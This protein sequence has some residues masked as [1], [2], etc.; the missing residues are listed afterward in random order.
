LHVLGAIERAQLPRDYFVAIGR[1]LRRARLYGNAIVTMLGTVGH[2]DMA[3]EVADLLARLQGAEWVLS[4][5]VFGDEVVLSLRATR[6]ELNAGQVIQQ[7]VA[8]GGSAGGHG[9]AAG[10][11]IRFSGSPTS[12]QNRFARRFAEIMGFSPSDGKPL[13]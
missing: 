4:I 3:A 7:L 2:P 12:A 10:G 9:T 1:A 6:P 8:G 11:R 5:A 13:I